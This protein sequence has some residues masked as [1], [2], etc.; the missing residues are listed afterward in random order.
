MARSSSKIER[1]TDKSG[2]VTRPKNV[3]KVSRPSTGTEP[4]SRPSSSGTVTRPSTT[5]PETE[6]VNATVTRPKATSGRVDA[7]KGK[8]QYITDSQPEKTTGR[9]DAP[10]G[11]WQYITDGSEEA[12]LEDKSTCQILYVLSMLAY[13]SNKSL[14]NRLIGV[15]VRSNLQLPFQ[16]CYYEHQQNQAFDLAKKLLAVGAKIEL[17]KEITINIPLL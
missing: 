13:G 17:K 7:P 4:V 16:I 10:V 12:V 14:A 11:K 3:T 15:N 9:V 1:N 8:G 5:R 2:T 6:I